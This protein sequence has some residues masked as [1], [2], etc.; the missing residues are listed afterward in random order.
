M[1]PRTAS[2][3]FDATLPQVDLGV[4]HDTFRVIKAAHVLER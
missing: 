1:T 2:D 3:Y 4:V